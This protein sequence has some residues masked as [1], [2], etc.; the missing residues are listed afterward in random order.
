M[1]PKFVT[2]LIHNAG[3]LNER[4]FL[5][6]ILHPSSLPQHTLLPPTYS[7]ML[8]HAYK[9][10]HAFVCLLKVSEGKSFPCSIPRS[11]STLKPKH[12]RNE[13]RPPTFSMF[14]FSHVQSALTFFPR[15]PMRKGSPEQ[16]KKLKGE[17]CLP[18]REYQ[19]HISRGG[20]PALDPCRVS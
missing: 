12:P 6:L 11:F 15:N 1:I 18:A 17:T 3:E 19:L 20:N 10:L 9:M 4:R 7:T 13:I 14:N 16:E 5:C 2:F 8:Y